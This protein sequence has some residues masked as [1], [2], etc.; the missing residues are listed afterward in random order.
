MG[1]ESFAVSWNINRMFQIVTQHSKLKK[2]SR[3]D[4]FGWGS[5]TRIEK[6]RMKSIEVSKRIGGE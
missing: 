3:V 4:S 5:V 6:W 1:M 2:V